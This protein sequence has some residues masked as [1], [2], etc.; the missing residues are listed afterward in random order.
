MA[1]RPRAC[2]V[3]RAAASPVVH[4]IVRNLHCQTLQQQ[5]SGL[6]SSWADAVALTVTLVQGAAAA[7]SG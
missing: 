7:A 3:T 2:L 4:T 6:P 5:C 1:A